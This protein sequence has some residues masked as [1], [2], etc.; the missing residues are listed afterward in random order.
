MRR[1]LAMGVITAGLAGLAGM[2]ATATA[3]VIP[4]S[5][6]RAGDLIVSATYK[7]NGPVDDEHAIL[8]FLFDHPEPTA[9][10]R[11][12]AL[13]RIVKN[14]G[15]AAFTR[16]AA[17]TVYVALAYDEQSSYDGRSGPPPAGTPIGSYAKAGRP[18]AVIPGP[19]AKVAAAFD[20]S[21]RW[22]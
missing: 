5:V 13:Q 18:V 3:A 9:A 7:G 2:V 22:K 12:I 16:I 20:D 6:A 8:V 11:P 21:R 15:T 17:S 19:A 10:S 14:G 4:V 1:A